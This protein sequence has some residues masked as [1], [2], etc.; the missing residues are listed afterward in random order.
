MASLSGL[1]RPYWAAGLNNITLSNAG[2]LKEWITKG[3]NY[4]INSQITNNSFELSL[5]DRVSFLMSISHDCN[6]LICSSLESLIKKEDQI[7]MPKSISWLLIKQYYSA[8]YAAN[9][10]LRYLGISLTYVEASQILMLEQISDLF[11]CRNGVNIEKGYYNISFRPNINTVYF[12]KISLGSDSGTHVAL[13]KIFG[14]EISKISD[15]VL[16]SNHDTQIQQLVIKLTDLLNNL[17]YIGINNFSW[18]SKIRNEI[19]YKFSHGTW[20][21]YN[22][23]KS[24]TNE[25]IRNNLNWRK[26]PMAIELR[27]LTGNEL[28]RFSNTCQFV[29][30]L[31]VEMA[32]DMAKR[33]SF[34]KSF[35]QG[36]YLRLHNLM[37]YK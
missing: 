36:G 12:N 14:S 25:L 24:I 21:P 37:K 34:G 26:D 7:I 6:A 3:V 4:Q 15:Q 28:L 35:H 30:S 33:C 13:W 5:N 20:F 27:N 10:I 23:S 9:N 32:E 1:L 19:N 11:S 2:P 29:I 17:S 22:I 8:F 18:L 16:I 31:S